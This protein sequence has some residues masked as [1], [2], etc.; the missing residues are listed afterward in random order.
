MEEKVRLLAEDLHISGA[1]ARD[2]LMLAGGN[3][4]LVHEASDKCFGIQSV[5]AYIIDHRIAKLEEE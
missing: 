1:L 3:V 4:S 2:L 5:K